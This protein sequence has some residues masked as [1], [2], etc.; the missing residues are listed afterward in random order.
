VT[1]SG[2]S[3]RDISLRAGL[4]ANYLYSILQ[5]EKQ[6]TM[7]NLLLIMH[8]LDTPVQLLFETADKT[9]ERRRLQSI[10]STLTPEQLALLE[11]LA[12][13]MRAQ[14]LPPSD[15]AGEADNP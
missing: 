13:Q 4:A 5:E 7:R 2:R 9:Q 6:P 8:E 10:A 14:A 11:G 3:M 15:K 1:A 12:R